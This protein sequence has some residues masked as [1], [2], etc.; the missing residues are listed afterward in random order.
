MARIMIIIGDDLND[1]VSPGRT[2][3]ERSELVRDLGRYWGERW[4]M[5][6]NPAYGSWERAVGTSLDAKRKALRQ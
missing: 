1:F 4:F 5:L 3:A 2:P 6:P